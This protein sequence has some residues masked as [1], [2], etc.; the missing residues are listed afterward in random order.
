MMIERVFLLVFAKDSI[1]Q[2]VASFS[3]GVFLNAQAVMKRGKEKKRKRR[4]EEIKRERER[5]ERE[6]KKKERK[7]ERA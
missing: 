1:F 7:K 4:K 6:R 3:W 5:K 2:Y